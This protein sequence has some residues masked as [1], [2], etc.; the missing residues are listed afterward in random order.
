MT[1]PLKAKYYENMLKVLPMEELL[2][3]HTD[4]VATNGDITFI[5]EWLGIRHAEAPAT[6][7]SVLLKLL[8]HDNIMVREGAIVGLCHF[9]AI[10]ILPYLKGRLRHETHKTIKMIL[11]DEIQNIEEENG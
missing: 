9:P 2:V 10:Q 11:E 7:F 4:P 3:A 1:I 5:A 8:N 6:A